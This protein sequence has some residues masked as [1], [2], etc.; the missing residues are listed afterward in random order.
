MVDRHTR[1]NLPGYNEMIA[2]GRYHQ[3]NGGQDHIDMSSHQDQKQPDMNRS[4][5]SFGDKGKDPNTCNSVTRSKPRPID[6]SVKYSKEELC[7]A[8]Q[9]NK[10]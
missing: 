7:R 4:R 1:H 2:R 8:E 9:S 10:S 6:N 3:E 5:Q